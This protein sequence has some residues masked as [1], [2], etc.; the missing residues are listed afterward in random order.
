V[1]STS[2]FSWISAPL[3]FARHSRVAVVFAVVVFA[4]PLP[5]AVQTS[6]TT[7]T[8]RRARIGYNPSRSSI[9]SLRRH[10]G[11]AFTCNWRNTG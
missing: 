11:D 9:V 6:A 10:L 5:H 3:A 2:C 7:A 8:R 4:C 1:A